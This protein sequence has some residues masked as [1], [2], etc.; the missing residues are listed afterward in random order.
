[1]FSIDAFI[2]RC[3]AASQEADP[4]A[5]VKDLL[6]DQ[7]A[8]PVQVS[9]VFEASGRAQG[10]DAPFAIETL[11]EN[12]KVRIQRIAGTAGG[13]TAPHTHGR[14]AVIGVYLGQENNRIWARRGAS[15]EVVDKCDLVHPDVLVLPERTTIHSVA[16]PGPGTNHAIHVYGD[17]QPSGWKMWHPTTFEERPID[18]KTFFKWC[19]EASR[20][21]IDLHVS[22]A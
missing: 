4:C 19:T 14:W 22:A 9:A 10:P 2:T 12:E 21:Y 11:F 15:I 3:Q 16:N 1:M 20:D 17:F 13:V 6:V 8:D 5:S 7:L 18:E